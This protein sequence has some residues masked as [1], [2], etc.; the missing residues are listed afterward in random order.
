MEA[1]KQQASGPILP[2]RVFFAAGC[3]AILAAAAVSLSTLGGFSNPERDVFQ[4]TRGTTFAAGEQARLRSFLTAALPDDRMHVTILG[5]TGDAGDGAANFEL[6]ETRANEVKRIAEGMGI[7]AA[8]M[9]V[10]GLGGT[11]ALP[12]QDG[13]SARAYQSRLARVEVSLQMRR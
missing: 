13:E 7:A 8:R 2:R 3:S 12:Q 6:S 10:Q 4:F 9:T 11:S 5:H 1:Q